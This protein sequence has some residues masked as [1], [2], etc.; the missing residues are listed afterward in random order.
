MAIGRDG[1]ALRQ[2]RTLFDAGTLVGLTDRQLMER[3]AT[4]PHE[5][6]EAG[7]P[8]GVINVVPGGR[9]VGAY[10]VS[11]DGNVVGSGQNYDISGEE[12]SG[13]S[14]P[15]LNATAL[16]PAAGTWTLI[17]NFVSPTPGTE[18]TDPFTGTIAFARS[19]RPFAATASAST[20]T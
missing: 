4:R 20:S 3:F 15:T 12:N 17:V 11:P 8:P 9:E 19:A 7:I 5:A 18:V 16:S 6:A 1:A 10:L 13:T 2:L 14:D